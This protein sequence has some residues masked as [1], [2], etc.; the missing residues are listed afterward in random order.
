[1]KSKRILIVDENGFSRVC[2][3]ILESE[4][5]DVEVVRKSDKLKGKLKGNAFGLIVVSYPYGVS[6]LEE[7]RKLNIAN[8]VLTDNIDEN[9]LSN[10]KCFYNSYCMIKPLDYKK[11]KDLINEV[12][13]GT[14]Q[15]QG[16]C[17][18]V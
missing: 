8:I 18:L 17:S 5:Y 16:G 10:L 11:F 4:G 2:A 15:L 7:I 6:L 9:L 3:A 13:S 1:M 14:M 12:M